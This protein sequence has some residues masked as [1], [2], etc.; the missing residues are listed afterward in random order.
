MIFTDLFYLFIYK[1]SN[2]MAIN[3]YLLQH[4]INN[5]HNVKIKA[6]VYTI[7]EDSNKIVKNRHSTNRYDIDGKRDSM[8]Y[9][10][11]N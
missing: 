9:V 11:S 5:L 3:L 1:T 4:V 2:F 10:I 6:T 8:F 7:T